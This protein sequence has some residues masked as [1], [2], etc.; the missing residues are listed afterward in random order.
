MKQRA[1]STRKRSHGVSLL[2]PGSN[3]PNRAKFN[4]KVAKQPGAQNKSLSA[5]SHN[6]KRKHS[7][8]DPL[9]LPHTDKKVKVNT[10][11]L[12][13]ERRR[14]L[15]GRYV[16]MDT[17]EED[18]DIEYIPSQERES[19]LKSRRDTRNKAAVGPPTK[20]T[21]KVG[22]VTLLRKQQTMNQS[23]GLIHPIHLK[24]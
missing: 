8:E 14:L 2:D 13:Q 1:C 4:E 19:M 7:H 21:G 10:A 12:L 20:K 17:S 18:S 24:T 6:Q 3:S 15:K 22:K 16:G 9:D 23:A 5:S 11:N